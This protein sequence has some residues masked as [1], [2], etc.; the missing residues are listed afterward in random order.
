MPAKPLS[1]KRLVVMGGAVLAV[2]AIGIFV[3]FAFIGRKQLVRASLL[4]EGR[5]RLGDFGEGLARCAVSAEL[6]PSSPLVPADPKTL[7]GPG[8]VTTASDWQAEAFRCAHFA[9]TDATSHFQI[10]W[11]RESDANGTVRA[12]G[13]IDQDGKLDTVMTAPVLCKVQSSP[14][15]APRPTMLECGIGPIHEEAISE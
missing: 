10:G 3:A 14:A 6:P 1:G 15:G 12:I 9:P 11:T 5:R 13:D 2:V 4:S 7:A 8:R